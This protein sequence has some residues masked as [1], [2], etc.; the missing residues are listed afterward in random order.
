M[1]YAKHGRIWHVDDVTAAVPEELAALFWEVDPD[2][3]DLRLHG[4]YVIERVMT[5]GTWRAMTWLRRTYPDHVLADFVRRRG[6]ASLPPREH[7][8]W[9]LVTGCE[10]DAATGGGRPRWAGP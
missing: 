5:R 7:A 8:Y 3:I 2:T 1:I 6:S 10:V 4:D 9:A